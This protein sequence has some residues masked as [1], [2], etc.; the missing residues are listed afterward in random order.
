MCRG[1]ELH[2]PASHIILTG[3]LNQLPDEVVEEMT[4]LKQVV[5]Q[6]TRGANILDLIYVSNPQLFSTIRVVTSLV[7]SDHKAVV[8][9]PDV[10]SATQHQSA[11]KRTFRQKTPGQHALF[12][13]H[14]AGMVIFNP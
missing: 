12:L 3:D 9:F 11:F 10:N 8:A 13:Q 14:D 5:Q 7:R 4:G 1:A 6:Q 2:Y